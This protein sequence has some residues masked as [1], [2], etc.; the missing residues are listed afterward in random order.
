MNNKTT[1]NKSGAKFFRTDLHIHTPKSSDYKVT[2]SFKEIVRV[3]IE[4]K[5]D[6][7]AITDHNSVDGCYEVIRAA[8]GS[9]LVVLPGVEIT[10]LGGEKAIHILAIFDCGTTQEKINDVL[11][12]VGI[13]TEKHGKQDALTDKSLFDVLAEIQSAGGLAIAAHVDETHG[14]LEE[15]KGQQRK[16]VFLDPRLSGFQIVNPERIKYLN[17]VCESY[18]R[19]P[20]V[21]IQASDAHSLEEIGRKVTRLKMD[22]PCIEGLRQALL[23]PESRIRPDEEQ[24]LK[25]YPSIVSLS[26]NG[27][28][29][30]KLDIQFNKNLNCL[31]GGRGAGKTTL[32]ELI[33]YCLDTPSQLSVFAERSIDMVRNVLGQGEITCQ[34]QSKTGTVYKVE[35][36]FGQKPRVFDDSGKEV[37]VSPIS[38]LEHVV[39]YSE[40]EIE[41]ISFDASSQ[42][43]LIDK[44]TLGLKALIDQE[45]EFSKQLLK[46]S[47]AIT[48]NKQKILILEQNLAELLSIET[49]L[50]ELKK[51]NFENKLDQQRKR[52]KEEHL[53]E[54]IVDVCTELLTEVGELPTIDE[55]SQIIIDAPSEEELEHFPNKKIIG[56][57]LSILNS[58]QQRFLKDV[59]LEKKFL[60]SMQKKI[61][62]IA[63]ALQKKHA[64]Q[65][66]ATI[67][68]FKKLEAEGE[69]E[70]ARRYM[71]LQS[72]R[73]VLQSDSGKISRLKRSTKKLED[74]RT[75]LLEKLKK[76]R[77]DI[78]KRRQQCAAELS[79]KLG[80]KIFVEIEKEG[81]TK[82]YFELL[83]DALKGSRVFSKDIEKIVQNISPFELFNI[84]EGKELDR[85]VKIGL[86]KSW[87]EVILNY[88]PL[89]EKLYEIQ[90]IPLPDLP[91]ISLEVGGKKKA[92]SNISLGQRCTTLLSLIMLESD[93]PLIIDTPEEGLDNIF[94][95]DSVVKNL[96]N[97]KEQRQVL[98]ATHNANIPVS[99]DAELIIY[100]ESDGKNGWVACSGSIDDSE[101]KER[102][103]QVLEGGKEAFLLRKQKY[104]Y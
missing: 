103:Q 24:F 89:R 62:K 1:K 42:L 66:K 63:S 10:V 71:E 52:V 82:E 13:G 45:R 88:M 9:K 35:R 31:I 79:E 68:L 74:K 75:V 98:L 20:T 3:A 40:S 86:S 30:D 69:S 37:D 57:A 21:C 95:F 100:L 59:E 29:L 32:I 97:I 46:N 11:A 56:Q 58:I 77:T 51:H 80:S 48:E 64:I 99:G 33:R 104:G 101:I 65:E 26:V 14:I 96:R 5:L 23:D 81:N 67:P 44:F 38:L 41:H 6:I 87:A 36:L 55:I 25:S 16:K 39:C 92:L 19:K 93:F 54:E 76:T 94:V 73:L 78:F 102:V 83:K 7:I 47:R 22:N 12:R 17:D 43:G 85:L 2:T 50:S 90:Q 34:I 61:R 8:K 60:T 28:F 49:K 91:K 15:M 70:A 72:R 4:K 53:M 27:G 18:G 84:I